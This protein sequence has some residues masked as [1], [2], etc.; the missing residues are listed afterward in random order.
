VSPAIPRVCLM[1]Q[2]RDF[3][4]VAEAVVAYLGS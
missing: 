3:A 1:G 2:L 4:R